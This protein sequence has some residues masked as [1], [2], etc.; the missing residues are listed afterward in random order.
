MTQR[1]RKEHDPLKKQE[2][3]LEFAHK[4]CDLGL[5]SKIVKTEPIEGAEQSAT[6]QQGSDIVDGQNNHENVKDVE[7]DQIKS[8]SATK[9]RNERHGQKKNVGLQ[10]KSPCDADGEYWNKQTLATSNTFHPDSTYSNS[11][12]TNRP[13]KRENADDTMAI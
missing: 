2:I 7:T 8:G 5:T 6:K 13:I 11:R 12:S 9:V 4:A 1:L 10:E 3:E